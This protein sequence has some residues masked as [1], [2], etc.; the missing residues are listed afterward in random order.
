MKYFILFFTLF[1]YNL[2]ISQNF[3]LKIEGENNF[4]T[5]QIDSLKYKTQHKIVADILKEIELFDLK[6]QNY[7]FFEAELIKQIKTFV[8]LN[9]NKKKKKKQTTVHL[10]FN[11]N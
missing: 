4:E 8:F 2:S 11:T 1:L 10:Y 6:L 7:G 5:N 9:H 3:Y